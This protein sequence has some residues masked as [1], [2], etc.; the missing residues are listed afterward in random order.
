MSEDKKGDELRDEPIDWSTVA[1]DPINGVDL[2]MMRRNLQKT[3]AERVAY[4]TG[5][6]INIAPLFN[7]ANRQK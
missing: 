7:L 3:V 1:I 4:N 6:A 2:T 5:S